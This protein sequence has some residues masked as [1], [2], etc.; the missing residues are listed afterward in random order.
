[1]CAA[2]YP[3][4]GG[5]R[6]F[7]QAVQR[8]SEYPASQGISNGVMHLAAEWTPR[9]LDL[10]DTE[11]WSQPLVHDSAS[12]EITAGE[13]ASVKPSPLPHVFGRDNI[14][15]DSCALSCAHRRRSNDLDCTHCNGMRVYRDFSASKV[16][17]P[18][19]VC[20]ACRE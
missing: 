20:D 7:S 2:A 14:G 17:K 13:G 11:S 5:M 19:G 8:S 4:H 1:M 6:H 3:C 10:Y 18:I 12:P 16:I 9:G 15:Y